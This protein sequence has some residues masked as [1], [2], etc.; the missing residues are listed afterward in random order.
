MLQF[1]ERSKDI[2]FKKNQNNA[3]G[4]LQ[5]RILSKLTHFGEK[6][7]ALKRQY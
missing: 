3:E 6:A 7:E 5:T 1:F 4:G 2:K